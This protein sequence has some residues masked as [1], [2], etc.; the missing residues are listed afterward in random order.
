[1]A[2]MPLLRHWNCCPMWSYGYCCACM[3]GIEATRHIARIANALKFVLQQYDD[4]GN[5][6]ASKQAGA[7]IHSQKALALSFLQQ[8]GQQ[9]G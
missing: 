9:A 2:R 4:E 3:N 1:M 8:S 6:A 5:I 7:L